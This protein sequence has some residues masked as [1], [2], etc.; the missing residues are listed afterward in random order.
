ME[1]KKEGE[2]RGMEGERED[3]AISQVDKSMAGNLEGW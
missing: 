3:E 1:G 2:E